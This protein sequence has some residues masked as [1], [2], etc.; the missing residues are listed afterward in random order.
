MFITSTGVRAGKAY[1]EAMVM[2]EKFINDG[3]VMTGWG[4]R[5]MEFLFENLFAMA[6]VQSNRSAYSHLTILSQLV[7]DWR[8]IARKG[9]ILW[10]K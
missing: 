2:K 9:Q 8:T 7:S 5:D 4:R 3:Q 6:A 1:S 10:T